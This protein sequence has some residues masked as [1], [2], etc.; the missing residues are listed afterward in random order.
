M[1]S[2]VWAIPVTVLTFA[3]ASPPPT[4]GATETAFDICSD[5]QIWECPVAS[6]EALAEKQELEDACAD[7]ED[8]TG[9][10]LETEFPQ[11]ETVLKAD[12]AGAGQ[13][14]SDDPFD[15]PPQCEDP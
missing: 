11:F 7:T 2:V 10:L 6:P 5:N 9:C 3:C 15:G 12:C 13:V 1:R 4:C 8:P 14:C